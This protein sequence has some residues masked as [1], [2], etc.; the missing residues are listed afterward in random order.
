M[1]AFQTHT[2]FDSTS[3][4]TGQEDS[5]AELCK[6]TDI[7]TRLSMAAFQTHTIFDSTSASTRQEDSAAEPSKGT[8]F[9][10]RLSMAAFQRRRPPKRK[11]NLVSSWVPDW[12]ASKI[13]ISAQTEHKA[14][15]RFVG[16]LAKEYELG[17]S[18]INDTLT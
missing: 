6:G 14:A 10:T 18:T 12:K 2:I 15:L 16:P 9:Q 11:W 3:T 13:R 8:G 7:Q 1:A 4:S 5:A 17:Q